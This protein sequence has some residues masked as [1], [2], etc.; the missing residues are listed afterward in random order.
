MAAVDRKQVFQALGPKHAG[1]QAASV[2]FHSGRCYRF[3]GSFTCHRC[4]RGFSHDDLGAPHL[5]S[6]ALSWRALRSVTRF[7]IGIPSPENSVEN[8]PGG[9]PRH[10]VFSDDRDRF[11]SFVSGDPVFA[12]IEDIGL[13]YVLILM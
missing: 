6:G 5:N 7:V 1:N 12:P 3:C 11:R 2:N 10:L 4:A 9:S 8:F 13:R